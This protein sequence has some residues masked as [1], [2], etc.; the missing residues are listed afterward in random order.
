MKS[1]KLHPHDGLL[2]WVVT[3]LAACSECEKG[4]LSFS[5]STTLPTDQPSCVRCANGWF[6]SRRLFMRSPSAVLSVCFRR[7][8]DERSKRMG[9]VAL[10]QPHLDVFILLPS[11]VRF[12]DAGDWSLY[13]VLIGCSSY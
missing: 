7:L 13:D 5:P 8:A 2:G 10:L 1:Q 4:N 6:S 3:R 12:E 11:R 9:R